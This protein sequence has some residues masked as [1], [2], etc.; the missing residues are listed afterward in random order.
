[1]VMYNIKLSLDIELLREQIVQLSMAV[2]TNPEQF[3]AREGVVTL[4]EEIIDQAEGVQTLYLTTLEQ[5]NGTQAGLSPAASV[6]HP[7]D[8]APK[9]GHILGFDPHMKQPFVMWW[10]FA[11]E[12]W[13]VSGS[14]F[15]D[16]EPTLWTEIPSPPQ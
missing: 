12:G 8:T 6:W 10:N 7:I 3:N 14:A 11:D 13:E 1:M 5:G 4:L 16:E 2:L 9:N 15:F